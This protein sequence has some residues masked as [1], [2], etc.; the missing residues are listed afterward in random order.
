MF[1][2][3]L[4]HQS[5]YFKRLH[6][7]KK[8]KLKCLFKRSLINTFNLIPRNSPGL[9]METRNVGPGLSRDS[10]QEFNFEFE[11]RTSVNKHVKASCHKLYFA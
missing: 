1:K 5:L 4:L 10:S 7:A 9:L 6:K 8:N 3:K 2:V 11:L